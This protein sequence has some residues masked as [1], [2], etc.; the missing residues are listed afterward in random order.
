M[1]GPASACPSPDGAPSSDSLPPDPLLSEQWY[2]DWL[3]VPGTPSYGSGVSI[4]IIDT[5]VDSDHPDL[6][7]AYDAATSRSFLTGNSCD[8]DPGC[9]DP[10]FDGAGHGTGVA[11]I[12]AASADGHGIVGAAP[13]ARI[14]SLKAG[15]QKG[16]FT[17]EA[18]SQAIR[19]GADAELDILVMSF[20]IDP[21]FRLC[22]DAPQDTP[23]E[24]EQQEEDLERIT[25]ALEYASSRGVL[26]VAASGNKAFDLDNGTEDE[27]SRWSGQGKR[28]V[29]DECVTMPAQFDDAITVGALSKNGTRAPYSNTGTAIDIVAPGGDPVMY[30][31]AGTTL[32]QDDAILSAASADLLRRAGALADDG[33]PLT[34]EILHDCPAGPASCRYYWHES[35]TSF[36]APQVAAA[37]AILLSQGILAD[38]VEDELKSLASPIPCPPEDQTLVCEDSGDGMSTWYGAGALQLPH[39]AITDSG[40]QV[41]APPGER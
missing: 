17:A 3:E 35:G 11:G 30:D 37:A 21:W 16:I 25:S 38:E 15:D 20:T 7:P 18:T 41:T 32:S 31:P 39:E 2:L 24:R 19:Y 6:A 4:G 34:D 9:G 5:G 14:V 33:T 8:D 28:P 26:L 13:G 36:A 27:Y 1:G 23:Q 12:I 29:T 22:E 10:G 40:G